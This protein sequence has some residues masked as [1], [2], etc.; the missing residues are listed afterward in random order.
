MSYQVFTPFLQLREFDDS[1]K[2]LANGTMEFYQAGTSDLGNIYADSTGTAA[3]NPVQLDGAG[4]ARIFGDPVAY[5]L[6]I[7]DSA[8]AQIFEIDNIFPFGQG[9]GGTSGLGTV[10][11]VA[12]YAGLRGLTQDYD[13][14]IVCGYAVAGDGAGGLFFRSPGNQF[15]NDGTYLQ[16]AASTT[17]A[18]SYSGWIDPR[19]FGVLYSNPVDQMAGLEAAALVGP[20]QI[21]GKIYQGTDFHF[22]H[23]YAFIPGGGLYTGSGLTPKAYF[24]TG[25]KIR[26]GAPG[27]F[28]AGIKMILGQQVADELHSS[29]FHDLEQAICSEWNYRFVVD[30]DAP[31]NADVVLPANFATDFTGG[32]KIKVVGAQRAVTIKNLI[33]QG[34]G[35]I[36]SYDSLA[37]V[38][39]VDLAGL[40]ALLEWFGGQ[41]GYTFGINNAIPGKAALL[42]GSVRL[43][44]GQGYVVPSDSTTWTTGKDL[45]LAGVTGDETLQL[46]QSVTVGKFRQRDCILTGAGTFTASGVADLKDCGILGGVPRTG[47]NS[48]DA[49]AAVF[50]PALLFAGGVGGAVE[51]SS[52]GVTWGSVAGITETV[53]GPIAQ[54]P[55]RVAAGQSHIWKSTDGG[56]TWVSQVV[57]GLST[58][59]GAWYINNLYIVA[60]SGGIAYS[61]DAVIWNHTSIFGAAQVYGLAWHA[62]TSRYIA[63]GI[64]GIGPGIWTSSDLITWTARTLPSGLS[65][66]FQ[67]LTVCAGPGDSLVAA[68]IMSGTILTSPDGGATWEPSSLPASDTIYS[69]ATSADAIILTGSTG[70]IFRSITQGATWEK[71][72]VGSGPI[73]CATWNAGT[74]L[75]GGSLGTAYQSTTDGVTWTPGYVGNNA[76][77]QA[78]AL[79]PPV[80]AIGGSAG[81][82]QISRDVSAVSWQ[83][84]TI[85]SLSVDIT[86]IR[87]LAGLAYITAK[88]GRLY[89]TSDF[90]SFRVI[91]TGVTNDLYDIA[92]NSTAHS[93]S[94]VGASGYI[95]TTADIKV[96][97]PAW[98]T[99]PGYTPVGDTLIRI[100]WG[101]ANG[102]T[103]ASAETVLRSTDLTASVSVSSW[104]IFGMVYDGAA[105][106][107]F[108]S[109]GTILTASDPVAG[110]WTL[111]SSPS[112]ANIFCGIAQGGA[113]ILGCA[114]G[115]ILRSTDH[116]ATWASISSPT[117][118]NINCIAWNAGTSKLGFCT[119]SA[120]VYQSADLGLTWTSINTGGITGTPDIL[121]IWARGS[122][123]NV[124]GSAGAW[125]F[126]TTTT[127]TMRTTGVTVRLNA[128]EGDVC[129]GAS[130]TVLSISTGTIADHTE[131]L[132]IGSDLT[133]L[134][135]GVALD[136]IGKAWVLSA[137]GANAGRSDLSDPACT[138][139]YA[140]AT[141]LYAVGA[142]VWKSLT[143]SGYYAWDKIIAK[144]TALLDLASISGILYA[145]G[146]DGYFASSANGII[147]QW[148]GAKYDTADHYSVNL[149]RYGELS[150]GVTGVRAFA[151]GSGAVV[152]AGISGLV[153]SGS[154][155]LAPVFHAIRI[156]ADTVAANVDLGSTN[157][158]TIK[159]SSLRSVSAIG[160]TSD[161]SFSRFHGSVSGDLVRVTMVQAS[162][163]AISGD[164][165]LIAESSLSKSDVMDPD[166]LPLLSFSG[167]R[168][169]LDNCLVEF[170][171]SLIYSENALPAI[172]VNGCVNSSGFQDPISNGYAKIS[173]ITGDRIKNTQ[174]SSINGVSVNPI[175]TDPSM[176]PLPAG[177]TSLTYWRNL[178]AGTTRAGEILTTGSDMVIGGGVES[179]DSIRYY[180]YPAGIRNP[181]TLIYDQLTSM[182]ERGGI[183][184]LEVVLPSGKSLRGG[185]KVG[186]VFPGL[187]L[188]LGSDPTVIKIGKNFDSVL[189]G[190][191]TPCPPVKSG[192]KVAARAYVWAG[193]NTNIYYASIVAKRWIDVWGDDTIT[194][195]AGN[196]S[197]I[198]TAAAVIYSDESVVIPAGSQ[199][200][201][202]ITHCVPGSRE[203]YDKF[204]PESSQSRLHYVNYYDG[205]DMYMYEHDYSFLESN[206][207]G[208]IVKAGWLPDFDAPPNKIP[209]GV[210]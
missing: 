168:L 83:S 140:D 194:S 169:Q 192:G 8:G 51:T 179:K 155:L 138:N 50:V 85:P 112:A 172:V 3:P 103:I 5:K 146:S 107:Q 206:I 123:W 96:N 29:W 137:S 77:V 201:M 142:N 132:A 26:E 151:Q 160:K 100:A 23:T 72:S 98:V 14:V 9:A 184:D 187:F 2:L 141:A 131:K 145:S 82:I 207:N 66:G 130:G 135:S 86:N 80:Y 95:A 43:L 90:L 45:I 161:T 186:F 119:S 118:Q 73:L 185:L 122:E 36:V 149:Y 175:S 27:A 18:R 177:E 110:P 33:Y 79:T 10:A 114:G 104:S 31:A 197:V 199:I 11:I 92:Y 205:S 99:P 153:Q 154:N 41:A 84:V 115:V 7:K 143:S 68:G 136:S 163:I 60:G 74:F 156:D 56:Q 181:G 21:S 94:V 209:T 61:S 196:D 210:I 105:Y 37:H 109:S 19:W 44:E 52:D 191:S 34:V 117:S 195:V 53:S 89:S 127:W 75:L 38:G 47:A 88:G 111:R 97:S 113:V 125:A 152:L 126:T 147:W 24:D 15:D 174:I 159:G 124:C 65:S 167:T 55:I 30:A 67:L 108:G 200:K 148:A 22:T 128:G 171:G 139:L 202:T 4:T 63:C 93:W 150:L 49:S 198:N 158:G 48:Q 20:V 208:L 62:G 162:T 57:T 64:T 17:Y 40:P 71:L 70:S 133:R 178:P 134:R 173:L 120:G 157:P 164:L 12:N 16:R 188:Q 76:N 1:G 182:H 106:I 78:V 46:D 42:S 69:S 190:R 101:A 58:V 87:V 91:P 180:G 203:E 121:G 28:G 144:P 183:I 165:R 129:V 204:F 25:A 166:K 176:S 54:G 189:Y 59:W 13:A 116:G 102:Y 6:I 81:S 193:N 39:A 32:A 35:Q 170:N